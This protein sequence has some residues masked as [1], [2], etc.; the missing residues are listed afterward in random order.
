MGVAGGA[1]L[2][3]CGAKTRAGCAIGY[4]APSP[5]P[6][7]QSF[8]SFLT[9]RLAVRS[10]E[11]W[12]L[13]VRVHRGEQLFDVA[14]PFDDIDHLETIVD[15]AG[16]LNAVLRTSGR[17]SGLAR[18]RVPGRSA[19]VRHFCRSPPTNRRPTTKLPLCRVMYSKIFLKL[20]SRPRHERIGYRPG[21]KWRTSN[22]RPPSPRNLKARK[23]CQ[24]Q[25]KE[26]HIW[27]PLLRSTFVNLE[28]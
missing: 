19:R 3:R 13:F 5:S 20:P 27:T 26:T 9:R 22:R 1:L 16:P 7:D 15:V 25:A 6:A 8:Q 10:S 11:A 4:L 18:Q 2:Q 21:P 17:N 28:I 24:K 14:M 12:V 23:R